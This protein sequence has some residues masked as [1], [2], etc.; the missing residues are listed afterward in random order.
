VTSNQPPDDIG[1]GLGGARDGLGGS[2]HG[3]GRSL[4][5]GAKIGKGGIE[6]ITTT[7]EAGVGGKQTFAYGDKS[8]WAELLTPIMLFYNVPTKAEDDLTVIGLTES[9]HPVRRA[10]I[11]FKLLGKA[12]E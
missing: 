8:K 12:E 5:L 2:R 3:K 4:G 9:V 11:A 10:E 6:P 7:S 1:R